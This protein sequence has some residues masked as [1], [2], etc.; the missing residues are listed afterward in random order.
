MKCL[1][2]NLEVIK[3][4]VEKFGYIKMNC[5]MI[6]EILGKDK[7]RAMGT[8]YLWYSIYE[9]TYCNLKYTKKSHIFFWM[10]EN[11]NDQRWNL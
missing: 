9:N 4:Q 7:T 10:K 2:D 6:K 1:P 8:K 5:P 11:T 3:E